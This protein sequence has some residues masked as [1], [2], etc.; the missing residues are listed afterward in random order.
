MFKQVWD[1]QAG[2]MLYQSS[3]LCAAVPTCLAVDAAAARLAMGCADGSMRQ[4]DL[5]QLPAC[6][7]LQVITMFCCDF[8]P[9]SSTVDSLEQQR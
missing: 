5:S 8:L 6:R 3:V 1:L 7:E 9:A 2:Q 4:F